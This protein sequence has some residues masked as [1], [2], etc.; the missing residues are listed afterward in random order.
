V[1]DW[2]AIALC[3][4]SEY[5]FLMPSLIDIEP[6]ALALSEHDRAKLAS[7]LLAS[8]PPVLDEADGGVAEALRR[9]AEAEA[10]PS[11]IQSLEQFSAGLKALRGQ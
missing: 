2:R 5:P 4:F 8:L 9:E 3:R 1:R 6:Q 11:V 10:D 7:R